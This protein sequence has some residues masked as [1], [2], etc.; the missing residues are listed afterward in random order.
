MSEIGPH[1]RLE[2]CSIWCEYEKNSC[3]IFLIIQLNVIMVAYGETNSGLYPIWR[4]V[5]KTGHR[6]VWLK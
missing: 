1:V 4:Y 5:N 3:G 6:V 2:M